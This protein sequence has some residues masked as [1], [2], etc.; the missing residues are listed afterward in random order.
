[1]RDCQKKLNIP[2][3]RVSFIQ[4]HFA[5]PAYKE[6][7]LTW[8]TTS[9]AKHRA[10]T[11][12]WCLLPQ[13]RC[14]QHPSLLYSKPFIFQQPLPSPCQTSSESDLLLESFG[15][16]HGPAYTTCGLG[17]SSISPL[18]LEPHLPTPV[19]R[20]RFGGKEQKGTLL[21]SKPPPRSRLGHR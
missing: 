20:P 13:R 18:C 17:S 14:C 16:C 12:S 6:I 4:R 8:V 21:N 19:P 9:W 5:S 7:K 1:M 3:V 15:V 11:A 10:S 2:S